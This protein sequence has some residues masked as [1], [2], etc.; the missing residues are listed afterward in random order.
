MKA[1]GCFVLLFLHQVFQ[2][3][4][5]GAESIRFLVVGLTNQGFCVMMHIW[6]MRVIV[7]VQ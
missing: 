7:D 2:G 5:S 1:G 4:W 6:D 3:T